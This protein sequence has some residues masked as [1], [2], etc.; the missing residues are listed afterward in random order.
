M[1][2]IIHRGANQIGGCITEIATSRS[3]ILID[4]GHNLPCANSDDCDKFANADVIAKLCENCDAVFY[5]HYHGDHFDL[6]RYVPDHT[7][8][9][10]GE[11]AKSILIQKYKYLT[12]APELRDDSNEAI[13]KLE[14][15]RCYEKNKEI[16][17]GDIKI[18]PYFVSHSAID[19]YMF[20][21]EADG[22][23][24]LHTGDFR[25]HGYLG[26]GLDKVLDCLIGEVDI[27]ITEGTMLGRKNEYVPHENEIYEQ[28][29]EV[30]LN[31][32]NVFIL[33]S[34]DPDRLASVHKANKYLNNRP[35][36][37]DSFQKK[38]L[39]TLSKTQ[40]KIHSLYKFD[41][42]IYDFRIKNLKL[43][44]WMEKQGFTMLVR[45]G[46]K[47]RNWCNDLLTVFH[48][49]ET[50][51]IYSMFKGYII[52]EHEAYNEKLHDFVK[53]FPRYEYCHTSGHATIACLANVCIRTNPRLAIIPIHKIKESDLASINIPDSLK[54]RIVRY[55]ITIENT[56]IDIR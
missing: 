53:L 52:P 18:I 3:R 25:D 47:Y 46:D 34:T 28:I 37:C 20:L 2:L 6:F 35:L 33:S 30:M 7:P 51:L 14:H 49:D 55:S 41:H 21:I 40:G 19:A 16:N 39:N 50:I 29:K 13:L 38:I 32:K 1:K 8:Q 22:K 17:I 31:Y 23:R 24:I 11:V 42:K 4:L 12:K 36:I 9:Y 54:S 48:P 15:F 27:L 10:I 44:D 43:I 56:D 5:T 26:K 45:S